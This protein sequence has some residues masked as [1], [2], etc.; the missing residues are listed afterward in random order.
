MRFLSTLALAAGAL[1]SFVSAAY[2]PN[3]HWEKRAVKVAP[4]VLIISM[5]EPEAD[6]WYGISQF[7][8]LAQNITVP[9]LSPLYPQV[10][11][12]SSGDICQVTIGEAGEYLRIL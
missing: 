6:V 7:N 9:G 3:V 8:V 2:I 10:H 5:F 4:K 11:C 1:S 12:T